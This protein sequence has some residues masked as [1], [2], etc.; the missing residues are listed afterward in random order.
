MRRLTLLFL[1]IA[2][3]PPG[4]AVS[5]G[6]GNSE[7]RR[8][9]LLGLQV[10]KGEGLSVAESCMAKAFELDSGNARA[11]YYLGRIHND[12]ENYEMATEWFERWKELGIS[13]TAQ[14]EET[15]GS[16]YKL[17]VNTPAN[18]RG[19]HGDSA[20][21]VYYVGIRVGD[22]GKAT[23]TEALGGNTRLRADAID[24]AGRFQIPEKNRPIPGTWATV[25]VKFVDQGGEKKSTSKGG[26]KKP[27]LVKRVTP[28]WPKEAQEQEISG[29]VEYRA[30]I[31]PDGKVQ[32][33]EIT[34]GP[35]LLR[36]AAE[37]AVSEQEYAP[38]ETDGKPV[39][40]WINGLFRVSYKNADEKPAVEASS[41]DEP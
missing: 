26:D 17:D 2:T 38:A 12:L 37:K 25:A 28:D 8:F 36:E 20:S 13:Q 29:R 6:L 40:A 24:D 23:R 21:G 39:T 34:E 5:E 18:L 33:V 22:D 27:K 41:G 1:L 35:Q 10:Y 19:A 32:E 4:Q 11:T 7:S 9:F 16:P 31:G 30:K 14:I 3:L 15:V